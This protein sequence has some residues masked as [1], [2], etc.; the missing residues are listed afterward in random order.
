[1]ESQITK[2][3]FIFLEPRHAE[4]FCAC[5]ESDIICCMAWFRAGTISIKE[6]SAL[7]R[8]HESSQGLNAY[9]NLLNYEGTQNSIPLT[10]PSFRDFTRRERMK[11]KRAVLSKLIAM[12]KGFVEIVRPEMERRQRS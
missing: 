6:S 12:L 8:A 10:N 5:D 9:A 2:F 1:M 7:R 3:A 11:T 4:L